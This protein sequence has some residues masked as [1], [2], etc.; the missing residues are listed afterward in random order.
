[1]QG[2]DTL[3]PNVGNEKQV[4]E[5]N[6]KLGSNKLL[7]TNIRVSKQYLSQYWLVSL[8]TRLNIGVQKYLSI[9]D[10]Q[11]ELSSP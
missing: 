2:N 9:K 6:M 11:T 1:M 5:S 7:L 10:N 8:S 4:P 3:E